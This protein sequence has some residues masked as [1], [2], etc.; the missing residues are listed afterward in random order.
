MTVPPVYREVL[1]GSDVTSWA[2]SGMTSADA[3]ASWYQCRSL[4]TLHMADPGIRWSDCEHSMDIPGLSGNVLF[5][6][7][8]MQCPAFISIFTLCA[9]VNIFVEGYLLLGWQALA[10]VPVSWRVLAYEGMIHSANSRELGVEGLLIAWTLLMP[11]G[12]GWSW[13]CIPVLHSASNQDFLEGDSEVYSDADSDPS[14]NKLSRRSHKHGTVAPAKATEN[15]FQA[16]CSKAT[17][18]WSMKMDWKVNGE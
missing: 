6:C 1:D 16:S 14:P 10:G 7:D 15:H 17:A 3:A 8:Y 18:T 13:V 9:A 11:L 2:S 4:W 12:D 5:S